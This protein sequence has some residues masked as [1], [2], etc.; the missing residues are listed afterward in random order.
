MNSVYIN[1]LSQIEEIN[2][3]HENEIY[4]DVSLDIDTIYDIVMQINK[5]EYIEKSCSKICF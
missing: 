5:I 1:H 2:F 4:I 3:Q